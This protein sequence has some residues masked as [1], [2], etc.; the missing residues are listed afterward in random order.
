MLIIL[1]LLVFTT[2]NFLY[3]LMFFESI[4][5]IVFFLKIFR[6]YKERGVSFFIFFFQLRLKCSFFILVIHL[7]YTFNYTFSNIFNF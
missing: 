5:L 4:S 2:S 3:F 1:I 6:Y 7:N